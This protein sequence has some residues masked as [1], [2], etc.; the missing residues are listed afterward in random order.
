MLQEIGPTLK[1]LG[2]DTPEELGYDKPE[3]AIKDVY[4]M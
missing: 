4:D 1:E 3:L 2:I